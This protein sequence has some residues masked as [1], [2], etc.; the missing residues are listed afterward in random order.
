MKQFPLQYSLSLTCNYRDAGFRL[1]LIAAAD[2]SR[3]ITCY[4]KVKTEPEVDFLFSLQ[5]T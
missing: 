2:S 1:H 3:L 4:H 5:F